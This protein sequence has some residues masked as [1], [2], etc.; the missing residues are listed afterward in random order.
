[1]MIYHNNLNEYMLVD[2]NISFSQ[3]QQ[4]CAAMYWAKF[5]L[6][7]TISQIHLLVSPEKA[8]SG[9]STDFGSNGWSECAGLIPL[10]ATIF[11]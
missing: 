4:C 6:D 8:Q 1:M 9:E 11:F 7:I 5:S 10:H 2:V 3:F